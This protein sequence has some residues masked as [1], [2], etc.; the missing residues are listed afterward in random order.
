YLIPYVTAPEDIVP[1]D[2]TWYAS[3]CRECPAGCGI[4]VKNRDGHVIKVEGNPQHPVNTGRLCPRGQASV[5]GLYNPDR[6]RQPMARDGR[7]GLVPVSWE[8]AVKRAA[9]GL[10]GG[11]EKK[12]V[13][14][15]PLMTGTE[16]DL[17]RRWSQAVGAEYIVYEPFAYEPLRQA[18]QVV[19][20]STSIANYRIDEADFLISFG[21]DFLETWLS[22]VQF[23]RQFSAF[24]EPKQSQKNLF[25]HVGP[26]LSLTAANADHWIPVPVGGER[27]VACGLLA[28]L[29]RQGKIGAEGAGVPEG[30]SAFT[31]EVVEARTGVKANVLAAL[32]SSFS[33]ARRPLAIAQGMAISDP[34]AVE[35]A[36]AAN[37]LCASTPASRE[38]LDFSN[39]LSIGKAAPAS[40]LKALK[41]SMAAGS[42]GALVLYHTNPVYNLPASWEFEKALAKVPL[43]I[44]LSSFP[45]ET[46]ERANLIMP[47][48]TFLE[49]WGDYTPQAK[50][51]GLLQPAM[52]RFFDTRPMG[53]ILLAMGKAVSGQARFPE[54]DFYEVLR[55]SWEQKRKKQAVTL[56]GEAFW[57]QSLQRGGMWGGDRDQPSSPGKASHF[58][59][60]APEKAAA[61]GKGGSFDL[62]AYPTIQFF[63]GRLANRPFL[64]EMPDPVTMV[65]WSG[66]VEIDPETARK[67][68]IAKGDILAIRGKGGTI[69]A[70]ALPYVGIRPGTLAMPM[71]QGHDK[72]FSRY[73]AFNSAG[74]PL[75]LFSGDLDSSGGLVRT[76]SPVSIEKTGRSVIVANADG[77]AYQHGRRLARSLSYV[78]YR[79]TQGSKPEIAMPLPSGWNKEIDFYPSY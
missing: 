45:D 27:Y 21:A 28:M 20:G 7:G 73:G 12:T 66:W 53:D 16:E 6:Y 1:G 56:S 52:G 35:T 30:I 11:E 23:T 67:M 9:A 63:D 75:D 62:F 48:A 43:K 46:T 10:K 19:F 4:L 13:F 32:A 72:S 31:P 37:L 79:K 61:G 40:E 57:Q 76:I 69:E 15:S 8:E 54:K 49:S 70:P 68:N 59:F 39:A 36:I 65:T 17:A 26:R 38:L 77:S 41:E 55:G 74:N 44:S 47:S 2:A 29:L 18:N 51:T 71:G 25:I 22:N 50:V 64:Q 60:S 14:M 78:E 24:H 42:V 33:R 34:K 3:T 58:T 5:Q